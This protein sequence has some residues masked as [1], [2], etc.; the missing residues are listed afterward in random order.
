MGS[1]DGKYDWILSMD[2]D[3]L[4]V[5]T[6]VT[7]DSLLYRFAARETPWGKL[8]LD[9]EVHLLISEDGRGLAGGNWIIRNSPRGRDFLREV[10]GPDDPKLNPYMRHDLRDQFSLLWHLVRPGVSLP[11]PAEPVI[12]AGGTPQPPEAWPN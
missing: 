5:N 2:C 6:D 10:Y 8:E 12:A 7:V 4:V 11:M 1:L 3:S 9:P